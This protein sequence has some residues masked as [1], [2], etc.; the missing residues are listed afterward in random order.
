[1]HNLVNFLQSGDIVSDTT[2][3]SYRFVILL[4]MLEY[5]RSFSN[6]ERA[7]FCEYPNY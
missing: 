4:E 1:M 6:L 3:C 7:I 5:G 2:T